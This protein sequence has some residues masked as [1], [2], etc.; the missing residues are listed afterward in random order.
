MKTPFK[1]RRC[2]FRIDSLRARRSFAMK[3][4]TLRETSLIKNEK[5][6]FVPSFISSGW[7][8]V[9]PYGYEWT[10][11]AIRD[12]VDDDDHVFP[13]CDDDDFR[14][15]VSPKDMFHSGIMG[16]GYFRPI[17]DQITQSP[18]V[19]AW[20]E[21]PEDWLEGLDPATHLESQT[22]RKWVNKHQVDCGAKLDN[23]DLFGLEFWRSKQSWIS[24][25]DPFGWIQWYCRFYQG[26]RSRDDA[27]QIGRWKRLAGKKGRF[28]ASL[29]RKCYE[30]SS[31]E[32]PWSDVR[33]SPVIRQTLLHWGY[34]LTEADY[35]ES[36]VRT[37][38]ID[39]ERKR[40]EKR[41]RL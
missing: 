15:N 14:P 24:P 21:L 25:Q 26:R 30:K 31:S 10:T 6:A 40:N 8:G 2:L 19:H 35:R 34:V 5:P 7:T 27:R 41:K 20:R 29:V 36:L 33:V 13:D 22:Y 12:D 1:L 18:L 11:E 16:G 32:T 23:S 38:E 37:K 4:E 17:V 9:D 39:A 28:R 3:T